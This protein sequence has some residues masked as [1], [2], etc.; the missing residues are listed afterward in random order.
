MSEIGIR[1]PA[2]RFYGGGWARA[3]WTVANF[4][5]HTSYVEPCFGAGSILFHKPPSKLETV[6]DLDGRVVNFFKVCRHQPYNLIHEILYTPWAEDEYRACLEVADDPLED[7]RRFFF[8]CW[9]SVKGGPHPGPADFRWQKKITRRSA[10]SSDIDGAAEQMEIVAGRLRRVQILNRDALDVIQDFL[11]HDCL[12]YF[13]PPYLRETRSNADGYRHE[14]TTGW[15]REA[16][17]LLR[18]ARGPVIVAGYPSP[19]YSELYE[20]YG[21][22]RVERRQMT[23]SGGRRIEALWL[24]PGMEPLPLFTKRGVIE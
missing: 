22:R 2:L 16:A 11:P 19:L 21:W 5:A 18:Q 23:N 9:A 1:R 17:V 4:P 13:D 14:P 12:I 6:N 8:I 15:H 7:A 3:P 10:A 20:A 24:S